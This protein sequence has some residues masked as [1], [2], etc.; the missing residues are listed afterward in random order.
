MGSRARLNRSNAI[1]LGHFG[2]DDG[3]GA[4][5]YLQNKCGVMALS[6]ISTNSITMTTP[7]FDTDNSEYGEHILLS[8]A[9]TSFT[10]PTQN[11]YIS[12]G[13][14]NASASAKCHGLGMRYTFI[15]NYNPT[16]GVWNSITINAP[17]NTTIRTRDGNV[18]SYTFGE[19]ERYV[20]FVCVDW[21]P[22]TETAGWVSW[23]LINTDPYSIASNF[24]D[25]TTDQSIG[26][27]K[28]FDTINV[29]TFHN[30]GACLMD[31]LECNLTAE[32]VLIGYSGST[33]KI[34]GDVADRG[35]GTAIGATANISTSARII[36]D[37]GETYGQSDLVNYIDERDAYFYTQVVDLSFNQ[38]INGEKVFTDATS[39]LNPV[40]YIGAQ[41]QLV[42][43]ASNNIFLGN[44]QTISS[45]GTNNVAIG[46]E[47]YSDTATTLST[48]NTAIGYR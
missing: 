16:E 39:L 11:G 47:A 1:Y 36:C 20:S 23:V 15:K 13:V 42:V 9:I 34:D 28:S 8:S 43:D 6:T 24:V 37:C 12:S 29:Y 5:L 35:D 44:N 25:L 30:Q 22:T 26:G 38:T 19:N 14:N 33:I 17:T 21:K 18:S 2:A 3:A 45:A 10:L 32:S 31:G 40:N 41:G 27:T 7:N 48:N 46:T 4:D